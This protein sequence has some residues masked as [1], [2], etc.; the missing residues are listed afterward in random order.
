MIPI[1]LWQVVDVIRAGGGRLFTEEDVLDGDAAG[2]ELSCGFL[3]ALDEFDEGQAA[4]ARAR[5]GVNVVDAL[6]ERGP[7]EAAVLPGTFGGDFI[8]RC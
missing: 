2:E 4:T 8:Q 3:S 7:I 1:F 5:E 6:E